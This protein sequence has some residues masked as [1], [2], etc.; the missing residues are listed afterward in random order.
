[1]AKIIKKKKQS[2][3]A[4]DCILHYIF[5]SLYFLLCIYLMVN[6]LAKNEWWLLIREGFVWGIMLIT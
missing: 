3:I 1:M 4:T 6:Q 5:H 2:N